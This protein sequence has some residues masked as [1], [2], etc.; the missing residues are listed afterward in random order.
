MLSK[1]KKKEERQSCRLRLPVQ[2]S[3]VV[4]YTHQVEGRVGGKMETLIKMKHKYA[5]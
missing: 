4:T 1:E 2:T 5:F 3:F